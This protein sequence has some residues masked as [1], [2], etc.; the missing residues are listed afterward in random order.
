LDVKPIRLN[1]S[2]CIEFIEDLP[3]FRGK[4][5]FESQSSFN[6]IEKAATQFCVSNKYHYSAHDIDRAYVPMI[7]RLLAYNQHHYFAAFR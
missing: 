5:T 2:A 3:R 7:S 4:F 6:K 1:E